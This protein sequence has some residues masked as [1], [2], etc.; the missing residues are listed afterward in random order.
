MPWTRAPEWCRLALLVVDIGLIG[1]SRLDPVGG[2]ALLV[3]I[4]AMWLG[5]VYG[6]RGAVVTGVSTVA[7]GDGARPDLPRA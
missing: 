5:F 3:V 4:P 1:L 6:V 2:S 7:A